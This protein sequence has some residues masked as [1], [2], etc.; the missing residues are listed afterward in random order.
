MSIELQLQPWDLRVTN[1]VICHADAALHIVYAQ[2]AVLA[3]V[4]LVSADV[5]P[6][7]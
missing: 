3:R 6:L 5:A 4:T 7:L 1:S 2:S